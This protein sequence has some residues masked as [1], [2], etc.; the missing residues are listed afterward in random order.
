MIERRMGQ[1]QGEDGTG[2]DGR[3]GTRLL[4]KQ[5]CKKREDE[6]SSGVEMR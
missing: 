3:D 6:Q 5:Q 1:S 2:W 4:Y